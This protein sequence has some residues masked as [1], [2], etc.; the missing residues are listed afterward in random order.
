MPGHSMLKM[1]VKRVS[2]GNL[3]FQHCFNVRAAPYLQALE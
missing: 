2:T 1:M 3:R